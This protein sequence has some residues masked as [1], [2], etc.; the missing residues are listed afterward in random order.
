MSVFTLTPLLRL[1][2]TLLANYEY[3][4]FTVLDSN[5]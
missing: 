5:I 3:S 1:K 2:V 4:T